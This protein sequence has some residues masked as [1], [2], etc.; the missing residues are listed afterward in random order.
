MKPAVCLIASGLDVLRIR[1]RTPPWLRNMVA[2]RTEKSPR[3]QSS[4]HL[5]CFVFPA[6]N[7]FGTTEEGHSSFFSGDTKFMTN[8]ERIDK[9]KAKEGSMKRCGHGG[10]RCLRCWKQ[11]N[12]HGALTIDTNIDRF[13]F[14]SEFTVQNGFN[15]L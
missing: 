15:T 6:Y 5:S 13:E 4:I 11:I 3:L 1:A 10:C 7:P 2:V 8:D 12:P 9:S 14:A